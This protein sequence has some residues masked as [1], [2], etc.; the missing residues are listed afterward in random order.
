MLRPDDS[1]SPREQNPD[2]KRRAKFTNRRFPPASR[3]GRGGKKP[4]IGRFS[5]AIPKSRTYPKLMRNADPCQIVLDK[6]FVKVKYFPNGEP[7]AVIWHAG[8]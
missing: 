7:P 5:L 2:S 1:K 3:P 8:R 6:Y 4:R